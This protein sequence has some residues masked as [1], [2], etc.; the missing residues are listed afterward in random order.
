MEI[1]KTTFRGYEVSVI[2]NG[3]HYYFLNSYFGL[4]AIA[5]RDYKRDAG[6]TTHFTITTGNHYTQGSRLCPS[7]VATLAKNFVN[8]TDQKHISKTITFD[9]ADADLANGSL[10][11]EYIQRNY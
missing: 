9:Y 8:K 10:S 3:S 7:V 2:F 5:E 6:S 4:L 1:Y 11:I